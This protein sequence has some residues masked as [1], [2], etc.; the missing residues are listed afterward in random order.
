MN[1]P[2]MPAPGRFEAVL[3]SAR[4][5]APTSR[6]AY[7]SS[8]IGKVRRAISKAHRLTRGV[9]FALDNLSCA[10]TRGD[11]LDAARKALFD[12]ELELRI[13]NAD[14]EALVR[15]VEAS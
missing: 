13:A 4:E 14:V 3:A 6:E 7:L 8:P 15:L 2:V 11:G 12:A 10:L 5:P 9:A 1:A